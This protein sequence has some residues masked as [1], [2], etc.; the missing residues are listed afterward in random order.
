[1]VQGGFRCI[2]MP[3][4]VVSSRLVLSCAMLYVLSFIR[5]M[6]DCNTI[7]MIMVIVMILLL[8]CYMIG[9]SNTL[10]ASQPACLPAMS[11]CLIPWCADLLDS[12]PRIILDMR[13]SAS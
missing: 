8:L 1:M 9:Q 2:G 12:L 5:Y 7:W 11:F 13:P 4:D 10:P 3:V 6:L